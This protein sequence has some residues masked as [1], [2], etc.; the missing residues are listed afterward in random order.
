[1]NNQRFQR[2]ATLLMVAAL[3]LGCQTAFA[4]MRIVGIVSGVVTD[5]SG[6]TVPNAKVTLKDEV[7]GTKKDA[8][9]NA[10]GQYIFPDLPFGSFEVTVVS[11]GFQTAVVNHVSVVASQTT[12]VPVQLKVGQATESVTVEGTSPVLET[13][14]PLV[15]TTY[16]PKEINELP[17]TSRQM[18]ALAALT[19]GKTVSGTGDTRFNNVPGGA[20]EVTVDGINDASNGYKS[21]GTVFYTTVPVRLGALE[22][23]SVETSGL[24]ADAGA[25]SGVNIKFI[26]KRGGNQYHGSA[27][28]QPTSEQFNA[29][30]WG[31]NATGTS[32]NYSRTHNF[33]GNIGGRLI[34]F[35]FLKDKLFFFFNYEYVYN[36]Q[37]I[38]RTFSSGVLT[39]AAAAGNYTYLLNGSLTQTN[40]VNL[41]NI[42]KAA[43]QPSTIDPVVQSI[44][45]QNALI[46]T[47]ATPQPTTA[48]NTTNWLWRPNNN[49]YQYYPTTRFD[50]YVTPKEQLTFAWN[51]EHSWQPGAAL[52][53][54]GNK[55]NPFRIGGY[56]VWNVALQSTI[57]PTSFNEIRYGVQHSG[58]SNASATQGYGTYFTYNNVPLRIGGNLPYGATVPYIDQP[59]VTG[60]H[61]ITTIYDTFT[62][63]HGDHT[64]TAGASYRKTDWHDTQE[65]FPLPTYGTGSPSGDPVNGSLF[66][67]A[68]NGTLPNDSSG[69]LGNAGNLYNELIGRVASTRLGVVVDPATKN[70]GG[71]INH[72][73]TRTYMGGLYV[74]DRWR[75]SP[76]LTVNYGIRWEG[77]GDMYDVE[78][79]TAI[80]N[81]A[82][83]YGPS[84]S[85]FTPGQ[86]SSNAVP[87]M[88]IGLH[89]YKPDYKNFAPSVGF[90]WNPNKTEGFLGKLMGGNKTVI[91]GSY[92]IIYYDE[93]TQLFAQNL[94][95]NPGK[96]AS[97]TIQF[98]QSGTN[99]FTTLSQIV[100][101][102]I[103]PAAFTGLPSYQPVINQANQAFSTS[104]TAMNP[105]LIAPY[106]VNWSI[107]I[108]RE[109]AKGTVLEV[110][111]V[112]NQGHHSWRTSNLNEVNIF[113][114]GFLK[115][116]QAAQNNLA[117][118]N[119]M[120]VAQ[121]TK[122]PTIPT[123]ATTNFA[124]QG[125]P[126]Q[127]NTPILD[128]AF[129]PRG[130]VPAIAAASG[131]SSSSFAGFLQTGAAGS[132][133]SSLAGSS[134]YYCRMMGS[135]FAPCAQ[136]R[137]NP[138]TGQSFNAPG[139]GYPINFFTLN[140]YST[141]NLPYVDDSGWS[142]YNGLQVQL[143]KQYSHGLTWTNNFTYSKSL[144][145]LLADSSIQ[146]QDYY[147]WRNQA[148]NRQPS[149]FDQKFDLQTFGTYDLPIGKGKALN[150]NNRIADLLLGGWT[151]GSILEISTGT[152]QQL[153]GGANT[154]NNQSSG[155]NLAPGV[156]LQEISDMFRGQEFQK[157]DQTGNANPLLARLNAT[158]TTRIGVP[159]A[160]LDPTTGKANTNYI[161]VNNTPGSLGQILWIYTKNN[162]TWNASMTKT[163]R[164]TEKVK[165]QLFGSAN[166]ILNHPSW[167]LP[168]T[169]VGSTGF[170][171]LGSPGGARSM[172]FRGTIVF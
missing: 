150:L 57:S 136:A 65:T 146:N 69:D 123:L 56:F 128:A 61:Y 127:V 102:P 6:A 27:F 15:N 87:T 22:E 70:Y 72:T 172:S 10:N 12:D 18:L 168:S 164:I 140:P 64:I 141:T 170:G 77:Q 63:I 50:Y 163:Y 62:K 44:L 92:G 108:Q 148:L 58:D 99:A 43:G 115:D 161:T 52:L 134:L 153:T 20:V 35:G 21:G 33:G 131:Y 17:S 23:V 119:N 55:T 145:N 101:S 53:Q 89:P 2:L 59:N 82:A 112:G 68:A 125:L 171:T 105:N 25:E 126:G 5:P 39:P 120:T 11:A 113:E 51:I 96:T 166:N 60:R 86:L 133:A 80:P 106:T 9:T 7:N 73:W 16:E 19:P 104:I 40:T 78:G 160:L 129:G 162:F 30:S 130:T 103:T 143:R 79:I 48:L 54:G 71:F 132:F 74:Q 118:A 46:P 8:V 29:N 116:F 34:P 75:L 137:L 83:I 156:T 81:Q 88:S 98:G 97:Q 149:L 47:Y 155:V 76:N 93:G 122:L 32:R 107:G 42:A 37:V 91:R 165:F 4:Q 85:L 28:Y 41:L 157:V 84:V 45:T 154:F 90:A 167:G 3:L 26:T 95:N 142:S 151:A 49:L 135:N 144:S 114:N 110:R 121:L 31:A 124:N 38:S 67:A 1:M 100:A 139:A 109:L 169:S 159:L 14:A 117:I 36:P 111:Y 138:A 147:T 94:G 152:P 13:T 24:A 158:D 66:T